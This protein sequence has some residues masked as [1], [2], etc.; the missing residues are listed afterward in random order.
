MDILFV[1][2]RINHKRHVSQPYALLQAADGGGEKKPDKKQLERLEKDLRNGQKD[3]AALAMKSNVII[4]LVTSAVF[5]VVSKRWVVRM[6]WGGVGRGE[7]GGDPTPINHDTPTDRHPS[8]SILSFT[9]RSIQVRRP[10]HGE[11]SLL[12]LEARAES[13]PPRDPR[14]GLHRQQLRESSRARAPISISNE[15]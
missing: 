15:T 10:R 14:G 7:M 11:A 4:G 2:R 8:I 1:R 6:E 12:A 3:V 5:F 9:H 13:V